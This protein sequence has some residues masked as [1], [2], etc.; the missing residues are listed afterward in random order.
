MELNTVLVTVLAFNLKL[1]TSL[2]PLCECELLVFK[3]WVLGACIAPK[4]I[5]WVTQRIFTLAQPLCAFDPV[6]HIHNLTGI[7]H[8]QGHKKSDD[9][10]IN[11]GLHNA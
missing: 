5:N 9:F 11:T 6:F 7:V 1:K 10:R 3:V 4:P 2:V 8:L